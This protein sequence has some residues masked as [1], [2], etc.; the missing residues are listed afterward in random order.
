M[1]FYLD[2]YFLVSQSLMMSVN[3]EVIFLDSRDG[4]VLGGRT[5]TGSSGCIFAGDKDGVSGFACLK[6]AC[7]SRLSLSRTL[8]ED[9]GQSES[10]L[11][12]PGP[13]LG[14]YVRRSGRLGNDRRWQASRCRSHR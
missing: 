5:A 10:V 4:T 9:L 13:W 8:P 6:T 7:S 12:S 2:S 14:R 1:E 11:P 3:T